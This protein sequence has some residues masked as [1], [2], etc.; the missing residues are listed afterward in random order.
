MGFLILLHLS[1][2]Q[3]YMSLLNNYQEILTEGKF[4]NKSYGNNYFLALSKYNYQ[5]DMIIHNI[6]ILL[7][8]M[9]RYMKKIKCYGPSVHYYSTTLRHNRVD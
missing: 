2:L 9:I 7:I 4:K 5:N 1:S 6:L 3:V 8:L